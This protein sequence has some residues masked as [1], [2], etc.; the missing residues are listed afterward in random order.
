MDSE[1]MN[2]EKPGRQS[3]ML[4]PGRILGV[5]KNRFRNKN[6][7]TERTFI[8]Q[9]KAEQGEWAGPGEKGL[10]G[11]PHQQAFHLWKRPLTGPGPATA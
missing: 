7:G 1:R 10:L 5:Q 8:Q 6:Y 11:E 4:S 9:P 3:F 2:T